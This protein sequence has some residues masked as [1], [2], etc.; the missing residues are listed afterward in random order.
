MPPDPHKRELRELKR[1]VKR[2]GNKFRRREI[3]RQLEEDPN[4]VTNEEVDLGEKTSTG[5]NGLDK[6]STRKRDEE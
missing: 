5:L 1:V 4:S 3:K 2:A 6:D